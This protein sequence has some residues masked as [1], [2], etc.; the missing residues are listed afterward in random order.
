MTRFVKLGDLTVNSDE[1]SHYLKYVHEPDEDPE[2]QKFLG[3]FLGTAGHNTQMTFKNG[4]TVWT[5]LTVGEID[6]RLAEGI[7]DE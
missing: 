5:S 7:L 3:N 4:T 2:R 1:I 6:E